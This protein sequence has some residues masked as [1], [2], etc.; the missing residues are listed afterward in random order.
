MRKTWVYVVCKPWTN[1]G[2]PAV[3]LHTLFERIFPSW[4]NR[5]F[6]LIVSRYFSQAFPRRHC[7]LISV[8]YHFSTLSPITINNSIILNK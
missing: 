6:I 3:F 7:E 5:D 2:K 4:T 1:L 8:C